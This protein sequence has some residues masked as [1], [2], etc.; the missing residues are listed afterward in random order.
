MP[1]AHNFKLSNGHSIPSVGFGT[2][3]IRPEATQQTVSLALKAGY[4]S[5]SHA[6]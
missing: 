2:F 5:A 1:M 4:R 3:L 6:I